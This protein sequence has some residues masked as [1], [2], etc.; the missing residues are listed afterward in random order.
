M[1]Y[2]FFDKIFLKGNLYY[3]MTTELIIL[4]IASMTT[5]EED[6]I[7]ASDLCSDYSGLMYK[8]AFEHVKHKQEAEDI[9][10]EAFIKLMEKIPLLEP[11]Q[12][13]FDMV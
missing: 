12:N 2:T 5:N 13:L 3:F 11:I 6:Q 8:I 10:Q 9:M 4:F 1:L 7:F